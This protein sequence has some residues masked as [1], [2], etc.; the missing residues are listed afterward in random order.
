MDSKL[1]QKVAGLPAWTW[2]LIIGLLAVAVMYWLKS[3][4]AASTATSAPAT[5]TAY[6]SV[7]D[8]GVPA[9]SSTSTSTTTAGL[10]TNGQWE[11][12]ALTYLIGTGHSP[13]AS[14][15]A[16]AGY[17]DGANL[18]ADQ[19]A[20]VDAALAHAGVPPQGTNGTSSVGSGASTATVQEYVRK[21]GT[22]RVYAAM[23]DGTLKT[24]DN[25]D[26]TAAG[27]PGFKDLP[28]DDPVWSRP[29]SA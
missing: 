28:A 25:A 1:T 5:T 4:S 8:V 18:T 13:L 22:T 6:P 26:Y 24:I 15:Q 21:T 16:L 10:E 12:N 3:R 29:A 9:T 11:A 27:S 17:L 14:Q 23:S 7:S 20:I 2:G 19:S